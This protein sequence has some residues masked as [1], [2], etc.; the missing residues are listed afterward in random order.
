MDKVGLFGSLGRSFAPPRSDS[1]GPGEL[2]IVGSTE[3]LSDVGA[4][5]RSRVHYTHAGLGADHWSGPQ[6]SPYLVDAEI[7]RE[8]R[9]HHPLIAF[10][11]APVEPLA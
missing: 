8:A 9:P 6:R 5:G 2:L 3:A 1:P 4:V 7:W 11:M 10:R